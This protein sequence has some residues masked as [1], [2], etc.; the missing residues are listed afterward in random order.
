VSADKKAKSGLTAF[1]EDSPPPP[2]FEWEWWEQEALERGL[3]KD[4]AALGRAVLREAL[5]H[6]WSPQLRVLCC[7]EV[8]DELLVNAPRQARRLYAVLLE[9]DGL[10]VAFVEDGEETTSETIDL[11][12]FTL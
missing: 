1:W 12:G 2:R 11:G 3:D 5:Q 6:N 4:L 9:T 7:A 10:R 8:L